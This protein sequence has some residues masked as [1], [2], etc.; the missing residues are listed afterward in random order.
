M[1][2]ALQARTWNFAKKFRSE[3]TDSRSVTKSNSAPS[4]AYRLKIVPS[5]NAELGLTMRMSS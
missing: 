3:Y 2:A 4:N 1:S 5:D